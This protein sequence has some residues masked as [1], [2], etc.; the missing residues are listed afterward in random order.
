VVT[1]LALGGPDP[2]DRAWWPWRWLMAVLAV[3][4]A[5]DIAMTVV[6]RACGPH[7]SDGTSS[8]ALPDGPTEDL[9]TLVAIPAMLS[10]PEQIEELVERLEVHYLAD[11]RASS[12]LPC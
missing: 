6:N 4:P 10:R 3:I 8:L 11:P 5:T 9:R 2:H 7:P 12:T 1:A